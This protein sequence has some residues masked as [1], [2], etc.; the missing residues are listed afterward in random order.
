[1]KFLFGNP[2]EY[3]QHS[4]IEAK[5]IDQ[6]IKFFK[7][8]LLFPEQCVAPEFIAKKEYR[9]G[10]VPEYDYEWQGT[11]LIHIWVEQEIPDSQ[12]SFGRAHTDWVKV[13]SVA[14]SECINVD[15]ASLLPQNRQLLPAHEAVPDDDSEELMPVIGR[16]SSLASLPKQALRTIESEIADLKAKCELEM[17]ILY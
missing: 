13:G 4:L 14:L 16:P 12:D 17:H 9:S 2:R 5:T 6:A 8:E 10:Q 3:K 11:P 15:Y 1:M 7:V